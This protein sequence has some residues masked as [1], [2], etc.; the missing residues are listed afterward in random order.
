VNREN[1][2]ITDINHFNTISSFSERRTLTSIVS[3]SGAQGGERSL[4]YNLAVR[5]CGGNLWRS[6][7]GPRRPPEFQNVGMTTI[8]DLI[9]Y[10]FGERRTKTLY[11]ATLLKIVL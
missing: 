7:P 11:T 10:I 3:T 4:N 9:E 1:S 2:T 8:R 5:P 6:Y